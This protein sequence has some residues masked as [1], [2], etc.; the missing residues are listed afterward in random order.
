[1]EELTG[2]L[3]VGIRFSTIQKLLWI[4]FDLYLTHIFTDKFV[5]KYRTYCDL[6]VDVTEHHT[7]YS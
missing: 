4:F 1:M 5:L 3:T 6:N 2:V 7:P